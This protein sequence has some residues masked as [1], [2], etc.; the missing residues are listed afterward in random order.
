MI[1][2]KQYK[3]RK[4]DVIDV[5]EFHDGRYGAPGEKRQKRA[6]LTKEQMQKVN[7]INKAKRCRQRMLTY[8]RKGDIWATWTYEVKN[9][10]PTMAEALKDFQKAMRYVRREYKKR[11]YEV[12]WIRNIEKGTKGAWHIHL[13]INEIGDTVSILEKAWEKGGIWSTQIKKSKYYD[14][15]FTKLS[16]YMTKDEN[17]VEIKKDGK[18]GKPRIAEASY[19]TSR[20]MP[21]PEPRVEKLHRWKAEPKPKKGYYIAKIH[22]GINPVTGYKY[23]RYTMI[24]LLPIK[25]TGGVK[26]E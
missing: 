7:A 23:R 21:L 11:G 15:D 6:K 16:N 8:F 2:R 3:F 24:R 10:P 14:E 13:I 19:N 4:G 26:R 20:N 17:T 25:N 12:F 9:R 1:R 5:E 18:P 22:E